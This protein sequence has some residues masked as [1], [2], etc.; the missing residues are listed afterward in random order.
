MYVNIF[1][2]FFH[3]G[4]KKLVATSL[5]S[6]VSWYQQHC[7]ICSHEPELRSVEPMLGQS[8]TVLWQCDAEHSF[9]QH[10]SWPVGGSI[11]TDE[12]NNNAESG[13]ENKTAVQTKATAVSNQRTLAGVVEWVIINH[14]KPGFVW[15][16]AQCG[17]WR[18]LEMFWHFC[19]HLFYFIVDICGYYY[20]LNV[21]NWNPVIVYNLTITMK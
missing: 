20:S 4:N 19:I 13:P 5:H 9:I 12:D 18:I 14:R 2:F 8:T 10:I 15:S 16:T 6:L 17:Q 21:L 1:F 7:L 11:E 3:L